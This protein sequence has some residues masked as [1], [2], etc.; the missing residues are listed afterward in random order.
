MQL[1][2]ALLKSKNIVSMYFELRVS[3]AAST[4][5]NIATHIEL[6]FWYP[7]CIGEYTV[8]SKKICTEENTI[9]AFW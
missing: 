9:S 8:R 5:Y 6:H 4:N 3:C 2:K 7:N 1:S